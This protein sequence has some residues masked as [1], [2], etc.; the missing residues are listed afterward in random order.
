MAVVK[1]DGYGH[2]LVPSARAA[3]AGGAT[4]LGT[5]LL[6]EALAL[7]AAGITGPRVL[8]WLIGPG[9]RL[10]RRGRAPTSTCRPAR[11]GLVD[12]GRGGARRPDDRPGCTSRST[13]GSAAAGAAPTD[14]PDARRA[15]PQGARPRATSRSSAS[16]RTSRTPTRP[17][18]PT[19]AAPAEVFRDALDVAEAARGCDPEVRH[20]ANSAAT[21]TRPST[22]FDLVRPGIAVYGLSPVPD[23]AGPP[24]SGCVRR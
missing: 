14:W 12:G 18:H 24:S 23:V 17:D 16:G 9:E 19:I 5:A 15:R 2:G 21:L 8:A 6:E 10:G 7:R 3:V 20:L 11:P 13:P 22:H 1:A 4:W